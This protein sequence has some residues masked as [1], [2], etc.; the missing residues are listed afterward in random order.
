MPPKAPKTA[1]IDSRT[2]P[3]RLQ[4]R[5]RRLQEPP[6]RPLDASRRLQD[7]PRWP[8]TPT[9]RLQ[10]A[11]RSA[12]DVPKRLPYAS[13]SICCRF[14][15]QLPPATPQKSSPRSSESYIFQAPVA[16]KAMF[17]ILLI[18]T[19]ITH[20]DPIW[21]RV[22]LRFGIKHLPKSNQHRSG[23]L[24]GAAPQD[25][26]VVLGRAQTLPKFLSF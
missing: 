21:V 14:S 17:L 7:R 10:D 2:S 12:E 15:S 4:E 8:Q 20:F 19:M 26:L 1:K 22:C 3:K 11:S 23:K 6:R 16:R 24:L 9:G 18:F 25:H 5:P 13:K